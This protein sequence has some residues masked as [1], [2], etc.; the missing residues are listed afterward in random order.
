MY[1]LKNNFLSVDIIDPRNDRKLLGSRYCTG[2]YIY[3]M[4]NQH[5]QALLSGPNYPQVPDTFDGQGA[6]ETFVRALESPDNKSGDH[7]AVI[8]VGEV[9]RSVDD[10]P[11]DPRFNRQ[12]IKWLDWDISKTQ[13]SISM[14]S[15]HS[16]QDWAYEI[17]CEVSLEDNTIYSKT[18]IKSLGKAAM[19]IQ[20]F[21]HP[22]FPIPS[23][24]QLFTSSAN[25]IGKITHPYSLDKTGFI[26]RHLDYDWA[27]GAYLALDFDLKNKQTTQNYQTHELC[28]G[29]HVK[30]DYAPSFF[31]IWGNDK[32][33]SFEP[34]FETQL[35]TNQNAEWLISYTIPQ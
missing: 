28:K 21:P 1:Q 23:T 20:W 14:S 22:F 17:T 24:D 11:F 10:H 7:L 6:P 5:G 4:Y 32:C 27:A 15:M 3:Q 19:P 8:G 2:G 35:S 31:P 9:V 16:F 30:T 25:F 13:S 33:F 12:V 18:S 34:Y 29:I 26:N